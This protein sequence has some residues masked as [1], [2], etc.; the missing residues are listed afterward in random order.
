MCTTRAHADLLRA[1]GT[2]S[3]ADLHQACPS[4]AHVDLHRACATHA[5]VDLHQAC[6]SCSCRFTRGLH[7]SCSCRFTP[8]MCNSCSC[9]FAPGMCNSCSCRFTQGMRNS[10]L[11]RFAPGMCNSCSCR[12]ATVVLTSACR[13]QFS[14]VTMLPS[15]FCI[16]TVLCSLSSSGTLGPEAQEVSSTLC[17]LT[18][19]EHAGTISGVWSELQNVLIC[20]LSNAD[21]KYPG[22]RPPLL[23]TAQ[24]LS[25]RLPWR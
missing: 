24:H 17:L 16:H 5:H 10:C 4:H 2:H 20:F 14:D 23:H 19:S 13:L 22:G 21:S 7:N 12:F 3:H 25:W 18:E 9:R 15:L 1:H 11:C 6:D 8:D